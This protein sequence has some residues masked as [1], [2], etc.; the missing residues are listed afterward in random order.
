MIRTLLV[1]LL[2]TSGCASYEALAT[3]R[4]AGGADPSAPVDTANG[5]DDNDTDVDMNEAELTEPVWLRISGELEITSGLATSMELVGNFF[6]A[7]L[8]A[9]ELT[10]CELSVSVA[11]LEV[12]VSLDPDLYQWW[13]VTFPTEE[14]AWSCG[15]YSQIPALAGVGLGAFHPE[16]HAGVVDLDLSDPALYLYGL[17]A[18]FDGESV[19]N[20]DALDAGQTYVVGYAGTA[21]QLSEDEL[22]ADAEA[23]AVGPVADGLYSLEG[24]FLLPLAPATN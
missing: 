1:I 3:K 11:L 8:G 15:D 10:E 19:E 13:N 2:W 9:G 7:N 21:D 18:R 14:E 20:V 17:Y 4:S 23:D 24:T 5:G 12:D 16:L 6:P 22:T